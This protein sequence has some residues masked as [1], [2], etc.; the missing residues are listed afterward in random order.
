MGEHSAYVGLD[1][2]N[3]TISVAIAEAGRDGEVRQYGTIVNTPEAIGRLV[4]RLTTRHGSLEFC[5]EAGPCGYTVYRQLKG[6]GL[7]CCV[8]ASSH[9][10]RK[11][12]DKSRTT[13]A[14]SIRRDEK[15]PLA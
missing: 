7:V 11:A 10:P 5:Y 14:R 1:V 2:H 6:M 12:A 9:T 8:I 3:E 13:R 15:M 4:R